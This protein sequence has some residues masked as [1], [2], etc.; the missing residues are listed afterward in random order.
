MTQDNSNEEINGFKIPHSWQHMNCETWMKIVK[1][2]ITPPQKIREKELHFRM[3]DEE[4]LNSSKQNMCRTPCLSLSIAWRIITSRE[5]L[6]NNWRMK[7]IL[8]EPPCW[9]SMKNSNN[10]RMI[11]RNGNLKEQGE[12]CN[13]LDGASWWNNWE[14]LK[15]WHDTPVEW[16]S[17]RI[18][19]SWQNEMMGQREQHHN[20]SR[21]KE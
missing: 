3:Q 9:S 20:A 4:C 8:D 13:D 1:N 19:W 10:K 16:I 17:K 14:N 7:G 2:D 15:R 6:K 21:T 18:T 12:P 5:F 11:K